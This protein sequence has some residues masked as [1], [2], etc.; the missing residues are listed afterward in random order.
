MRNTL[1]NIINQTHRERRSQNTRRNR[2]ILRGPFTMRL[3]NQVPQRLTN[4]ISLNNNR[5]INITQVN[6]DDIPMTYRLEDE[7]DVG[8][9]FSSDHM[10]QY[11]EHNSTY[12]NNINDEYI[13]N[14]YDQIF[15][16]FIRTLHTFT[17]SNIPSTPNTTLRFLDDIE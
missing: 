17:V 15:S 6:M 11:I 2:S 7:Y 1:M 10:N 5:N 8:M 9:N 14:N 3:S 12:M 13:T 16:N 4:P